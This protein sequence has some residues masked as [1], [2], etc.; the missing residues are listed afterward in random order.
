[1]ELVTLIGSNQAGPGAEVC[2]AMGAIDPPPPEAAV[3][4]PP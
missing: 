3:A 1:M 2:R 4:P